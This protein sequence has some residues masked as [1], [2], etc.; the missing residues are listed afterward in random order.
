MAEP[1]IQFTAK[2]YIESKGLALVGAGSRPG[3]AMVRDR[4]GNLMEFDPSAVI[5]EK[6]LDIGSVDVQLNK[7]TDPIGDSPVDISDR[8]KMSLGNTRGSISYLREKFEDVKYIPNKG[9]VVKNNG[10]WQPVDNQH[11]G[12]NPWETAKEIAADIAEGLPTVVS[13]GAQTAGSIAGAAGGLGVA[14]AGGA[15]AGGA[16]EAGRILMGKFVGTYEDT[17]EGM[18]KDIGLEALMALGAGAFGAGVVP[19]AGKIV[20]GLGSLGGK[21]VGDLPKTL[22]QGLAAKATQNS[23]ERAAVWMDK[24]LSNEVVQVLER[25]SVGRPIGTAGEVIAQDIEKAGRLWLESAEPALHR[26]YGKQMSVLVDKAKNMPALELGEMP[27]ASLAKLEQDGLI[28]RTGPDDAPVF[29]IMDA[30]RSVANQKLGL[31]YQIVSPEVQP[32]LKSMVNTLNEFSK[33][34]K[35]SGG[36]AAEEMLKLNRA[37]NAQA[38]KLHKSPATAEAASYADTIADASRQVMMSKFEQA[39]LAADY[40]NTVGIYQTYADAVKMA[41]KLAASEGGVAKLIQSFGSEMVRKAPVTQM[42]GD[43]LKLMGESGAKGMRD[44][45][46]KDAALGASGLAPKTFAA[47]G[48]PM[49][50]AYLGG[51]PGAVVGAAASTPRVMFGATRALNKSMEIPLR[52]L[53]WIKGL[54]PEKIKEFVNTPELAEMFVRTIAEVPAKSM[55]AEEQLVNKVTGGQQ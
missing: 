3:T 10:V 13:I 33:M 50:G 34:G 28:Y 17:P 46:V 2:D 15:A 19:T 22:W 7:P 12:S 35:V 55:M 39:G 44:L 23:M 25:A 48:A 6:G 4:D 32:T 26:E 24:E 45:I 14:V 29:K 49:M 51:V 36:R 38:R 5:K 18:A 40:V 31:P 41:N 8:F 52:G 20:K 37:L 53:D 47:S 43:L 27:K 30:A 11:L 42:T 1:K 54:P 21:L 16:A 9:L